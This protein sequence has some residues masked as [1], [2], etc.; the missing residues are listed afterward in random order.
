MKTILLTLITWAR[1]KGFTDTQI[2]EFLIENL[3]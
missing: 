2:L 3:D 1:K